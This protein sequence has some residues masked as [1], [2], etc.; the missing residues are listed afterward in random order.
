MSETY[1]ECLVA[2]KPSMLLSFLKML[3]IMLTV[4]FVLIGMV[5]IPGLAVAAVTGVAA[6]FATMNANIEYEYL[7]LDRE[8]SVDKVMAKSRRKKANTFSIDQ[9]EMLAPLNSHRLDS[10]R[11]QNTKTLDYSSGVAA[12]PEK[13]YMMIYEGNRKVIFE[14]NAELVKAIQ[15][16]AP[17]KVFTD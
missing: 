1:V 4:V 7:Y 14:P 9:M 13:R 10:Y 3:L 6:Y 5:F 11:N 17:R 16:I 8:I 15:S 2:R 12:Q